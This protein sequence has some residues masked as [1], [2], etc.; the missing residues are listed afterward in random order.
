MVKLVEEGRDA[1]LD[2][3]MEKQAEATQQKEVDAQQ[4]SSPETT[5]EQA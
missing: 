4:V 2:H 3:I 5:R 1:D